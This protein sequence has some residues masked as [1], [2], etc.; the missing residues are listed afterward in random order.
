MLQPGKQEAMQASCTCSKGLELAAADLPRPV[1]DTRPPGMPE[2]IR[3][4]LRQRRVAG[5]GSVIQVG[6]VL[7]QAALHVCHPSS[8][9]PSE[10]VP[11]WP[12]CWLS[13]LSCPQTQTG[14]TAMLHGIQAQGG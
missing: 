5:E 3:S 10:A 1:Q 8:S 4:D 7:T 6:Q 2:A 9:L 11:A 13:P 14:G 12:C